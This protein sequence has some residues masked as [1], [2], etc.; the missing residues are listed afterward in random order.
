MTLSI[1]DQSLEFGVELKQYRHLFT[2]LEG[3]AVQPPRL[4]TLYSA[5]L[6][7]EFVYPIGPFSSSRL[8]PKEWINDYFLQRRR[9]SRFQMKSSKD[10]SKERLSYS[11]Y[12]NLS[13][14]HISH[15]LHNGTKQIVAPEMVIHSFIQSL[16]GW[17]NQLRS[18]IH[19]II[20]L[21]FWSPSFTSVD[22]LRVAHLFP[23][24]AAGC[25]TAAY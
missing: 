15:L 12:C 25:T 24:C 5:H 9:H 21:V 18:G 22:Q 13:T 23:L 7:N 1:P 11:S 20:S 10:A 17:F 6:N 4:S 16:V 3:R 19:F 14:T 8:F 2:F